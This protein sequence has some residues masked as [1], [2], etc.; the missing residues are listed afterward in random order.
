[1]NFWS[2]LQTT[3]KVEEERWLKAANQE[4]KQVAQE[5]ESEKKRSQQWIV[6]KE[7]VK[8]FGFRGTRLITKKGI[9][10]EA[11]KKISFFE[12]K[13][14]QLEQK[15]EKT[16]EAIDGKRSFQEKIQTA[17]LNPKAVL[18]YP[19]F[20]S[21]CQRFGLYR[22]EHLSPKG[23]TG[24]SNKLSTLINGI[25]TFLTMTLGMLIPIIFWLVSHGAGDTSTNQP[26]L[27]SGYSIFFLLAMIMGTALSDVFVFVLDGNP[28]NKVFI[29]VGSIVGVLLEIAFL[30]HAI[31][32][33]LI[34]GS[35]ISR[36]L[37]SIIMG[38]IL[39]F[40][41]F[42]S[43]AFVMCMGMD[44]MEK[45]LVVLMTFGF[46]KLPQKRQLKWL[47][48]E[49]IDCPRKGEEEPVK[50]TFPLVSSKFLD[51]LRIAYENGFH[52]EIAAEP[53]AI[54]VDKKR[55]SKKLK[56]IVRLDPIL[57]VTDSQKRWV[58][59]LAQSGSFPDEKEVLKWVRQKGIQAM[60]L[61]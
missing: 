26:G 45:L 34:S 56:E 13:F 6:E 60:N 1:M 58:A 35:F 24:I 16:V 14:N 8:M 46:S 21:L 20:C 49:G 57:Y 15:I 41:I 17:G 30:S 51:V 3:Y 4:A 59:V 52:P 54:L 25:H 28:K 22:F 31:F 33:S 32:P 11:S 47:F 61:S 53:A 19:V 38:A 44:F 12:G 23:E 39:C 18:P 27:F 40:M 2:K 42:I 55:L 5:L 43:N 48:P 9:D 7:D 37:A 10:A 50:I 29:T 36:L